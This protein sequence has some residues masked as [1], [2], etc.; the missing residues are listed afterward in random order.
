MKRNFITHIKGAPVRG[1]LFSD[2]VHESETTDHPI[3]HH[4]DEKCDNIF[5]KN[6]AM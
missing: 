4:Y 1:C 6:K 2:M 5:G 3:R